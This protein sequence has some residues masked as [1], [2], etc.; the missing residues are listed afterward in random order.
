MEQQDSLSLA[1]IVAD[2]APQTTKISLLEMIQQGGWFGGIIIFILFLLLLFTVFL[3]FERYLSINKQSKQDYYFINN[4][5][6]FVYESKINAAVELC[7]RTNTPESRMIEKGLLRIGRPLKEISEAIENTGKLEVY[8]LEKNVNYLATIAGAAPMLGFLGTVVG[9]IMSFAEI[10]NTA[11]QVDA[12]LLSSG[13]YAAMLT[14]AAGLV[15]GISA[16][17][18]YNFLVMKVDKSVHKMESTVTEFLEVIN[19]PV[20]K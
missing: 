20:I 18:A 7:K 11:G 4:I 12:K 13:I 8:K 10:A 15:V 5:R 17:I 9:M 16:Y 2:T 6:D 3:F 14:T 1:Q 19:K